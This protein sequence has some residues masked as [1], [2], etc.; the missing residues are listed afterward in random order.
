[1]L[2][3]VYGTY[4]VWMYMM[5]VGGMYMVCVYN[6]I[7]MLWCVVYGVYICQYRVYVY[8]VFYVVYLGV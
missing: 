1:M 8:C 3:Y 4:C 7:C 2:C 6:V 5:Y